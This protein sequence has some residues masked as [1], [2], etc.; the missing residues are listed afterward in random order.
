MTG[1]RKFNLKMY[2][3]DNNNLEFDFMTSDNTSRITWGLMTYNG[4]S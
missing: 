3:I 4:K 2:K 1:N